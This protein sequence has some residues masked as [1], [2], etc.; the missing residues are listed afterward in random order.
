[1]RRDLAAEKT[2]FFAL[3]FFL[4]DCSGAQLLDQTVE[5]RINACVALQGPAASIQL[6]PPREKLGA[7][8]LRLFSL[9]RPIRLRGRWSHRRFDGPRRSPKHDDGSHDRGEEQNENDGD[10]NGDHDLTPL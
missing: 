2:D 7:D 5:F 1:M 3:E 4:A 6:Y 10:N 9:S 8:G